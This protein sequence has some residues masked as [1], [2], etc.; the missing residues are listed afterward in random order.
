MCVAS[1]CSTR[2]HSL[3]EARRD[4]LIPTL[5][6]VILEAVYDENRA[7]RN[8]S[9]E[10]LCAVEVGGCSLG[11]RQAPMDV[12]EDDVGK[13]VPLHSRKPHRSEEI[14]VNDRNIPSFPFHGPQIPDLASTHLVT[15]CWTDYHRHGKLDKHG[16]GCCTDAALIGDPSAAGE[17]RATQGVQTVFG[18]E[19]SNE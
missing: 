16:Q 18:D 14:L 3:H 1:G 15:D 6:R 10:Q 13:E 9:I 19:M 5:P 17:A 8:V 7:A 4:E 11:H 12:R 2:Q